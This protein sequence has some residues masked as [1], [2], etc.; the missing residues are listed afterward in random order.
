[1]TESFSPYDNTS[2]ITEKP[3]SIAEAQVVEQLLQKQKRMI[4]ISE[5]FQGAVLAPFAVAGFHQWE[6]I[7]TYIAIDH[8][9][10]RF[11]PFS[12]LKDNGAYYLQ[13]NY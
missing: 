8:D 10:L 12:I 6:G 13:S 2:W 11:I 4:Y 1:M 9:G 5:L 7:Q 3:I